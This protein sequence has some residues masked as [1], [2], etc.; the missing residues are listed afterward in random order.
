MKKFLLVACILALALFV[1]TACSTDDPEPTTPSPTVPPAGGAA[2]PAPVATPEPPPADWQLND[3]NPAT[4][5][6]EWW[7]GDA[8]HEA[9][10]EAIALFESRYPHI[11]VNPIYGAFGGYLDRL[12]LDLAGGTE[13]DVLQSNFAWV[14]NLGGGYNVF[15]D[16][17][18]LPY[19]DLTEW[20]SDLRAF[21]T[22]RDGQL[23][24]VSHGVTGRVVVYSTEM[25]PNGFPTT[26]DELIAAGPAIAAVNAA[27][28]AGN[29]TYAFFPVGYQSW[30]III[31]TMILNEYG[32]NLQANGQI[33]PT[34]DQVES[35]L[36]V[37]G[38]AIEAG[39]LPT[40]VQQEA[41]LDT[42]NPVWMQGRGGGLFEWVGNI[43]LAGG[44]FQDNDQATRVM[45]GVGVA[46]LPT[47]SAGTTANSMQRTSLV[48]AVTQGA[49]DRGVE[50]IAAYFLNFLYT[51]E[52][53]LLIL[54][55]AFG[56]PLSR[57]AAAIAAQEDQ[58]WGLM[59][60][61]LD[62]LT[63]NVGDMCSLFEDADLRPARRAAF[64]AFHSG[65]I[66]AR[67]AAER[68]VNDQQAYLNAR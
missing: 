64:E 29:N 39:A 53:A 20:S 14:H 56:I 61:G 45:E 5:S 17:L 41:P 33:L 2:D 21:T 16:H 3:G 1:A 43:H 24:G 62:L 49:V 38:A 9:V 22:T 23:S 13:A 40:F 10:L 68:W 54:G 28:D 44:N 4:I 48:H 19:L 34:V 55:D 66:S 6:F 35:A 59:A 47:M 8:R 11:E 15:A 7:G 51:D 36:N 30:D 18:T 25:S 67:E 65:D 12:T 31:M 50:H 32:V 26:W 37:I 42:T 63:A 58:V 27:V 57:S 46:L 60:E 52:E